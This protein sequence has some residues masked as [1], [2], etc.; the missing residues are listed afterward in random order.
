MEQVLLVY[1]RMLLSVV[2]K[3]TALSQGGAPF[4]GSI[5]GTSGTANGTGSN[6]SF[7]APSYIVADGSGGFYISDTGNH[8]IRK[9]DQYGVVTTVFGSTSGS[10]LTKLNSPRGLA[11]DASNNLY[12]AD[13]SNSRVLR[14]AYGASTATNLG[15][16]YGVEE[17]AVNSDGSQAV[18]RTNRTSGLNLIQYRNGTIEGTI[19]LNL[20]YY[21]TTLQYNIATVACSPS[22][23]FYYSATEG[24]IVGNQ[25]STYKMTL[26]PPTTYNF[27]AST[28]IVTING[29]SSPGVFLNTNPVAAGVSAGLSFSLSE[30][31]NPKLNGFVGTIKQVYSPNIYTFTNGGLTLDFAGFLNDYPLGPVFGGG[32]IS[33]GSY[34]AGSNFDVLGFGWDVNG[35]FAGNSNPLT[36][37]SQVL[38]MNIYLQSS[39]LS[40]PEI[41]YSSQIQEAPN[42]TTRLSG[43][44]GDFAAYNGLESS[45]LKIYDWPVGNAYTISGNTNILS[46]V[47]NYS[48]IDSSNIELN[49]IG[50][51]VY[52]PSV[53]IGTIVTAVTV[54]QGESGTFTTN[55]PFTYVSRANVTFSLIPDVNSNVHTYTGL[56]APGVIDVGSLL[57]GGKANGTSITSVTPNISNATTGIITVEDTFLSQEGSYTAEPTYKFYPWLGTS[58]RLASV[59]FPTVAFP[60]DSGICTITSISNNITA[61]SIDGSE[62]GGSLKNIQFPKTESDT[63]YAS[64]VNY[65]GIRRYGVSGNNTLV[66]IDSNSNVPTVNPFA[67][68]PTISEMV[69]LVPTPTSNNIQIYQNVY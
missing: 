52:G 67:V 31:T 50:S 39:R 33:N 23:I 2:H 10:S 30:F 48:G 5:S 64:S 36:S 62:Y 59:I 55:K 40:F 47:H 27:T 12:I 16:V 7:N 68:F 17:I 13:F 18:F 21:G 28:G 44:T 69:A 37:P 46:N 49:L 15:T 26:N 25:I 57:F 41:T 9:V 58:T 51:K 34:N 19:T 54:G 42:G 60:D 53:E 66:M 45:G 3:N 4:A 32:T 38:R 43:F 20:D 24:Q 14:L 6:A 35:I 63:F 65:A 1:N 29:T 8:R 11:L 22:G 61:M 56:T